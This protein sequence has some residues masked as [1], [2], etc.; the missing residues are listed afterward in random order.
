MLDAADR[1]VELALAAG[2]R[3]L[4][5]WAAG[6]AL[7]VSTTAESANGAALRAAAGSGQPDRLAQT[8]RDVTR[9]Y[10]AANE[11]APDDLAQSYK[12]IRQSA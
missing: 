1:L 10:G 11:P 4:A 3:P 2:D 7:M 8:W 6:R 5:A 9:R 12:Q